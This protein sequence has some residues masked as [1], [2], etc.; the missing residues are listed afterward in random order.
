MIDTALLKT[1][2][3]YLML[4]DFPIS[5]LSYPCLELSLNFVRRV[6]S[7]A[8]VTG[9]L[10][11]PRTEKLLTYFSADCSIAEAGMVIQIVFQ[12]LHL[13]LGMF[14][15]SIRPLPLRK[16]LLSQAVRSDLLLLAEFSVPEEGQH[17]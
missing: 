7:A 2:G 13:I 11:A 3:D 14:Y 12:E 5:S 9:T 4:G 1:D 6:S 17:R 8:P 10:A 16:S 15:I